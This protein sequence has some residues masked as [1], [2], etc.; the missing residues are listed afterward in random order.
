MDRGIVISIF[1]PTAVGKTGVAEIVR[2]RLREAGQEVEAVSADAYAV[3]REIPIITGAPQ[4]SEFD[5][6][7]VGQLSVTDEWSAGAFAKEA[8][9][10]IDTCLSKGGAVLMVGGTGLYLQAALSDLQMREAVPT[11]VRAA[12]TARL[13]MEGSEALHRELTSLQPNVSASIHPSDSHRVTRALEAAL[14]GQPPV[15]EAGIWTANLRQPTRLF[16]LTMERAPLRERINSRIEG[17]IAAGAA[18]EVEGAWAL[19]PSRTAQAAIGMRELPEGDVDRMR[20]RTHQF[21]KRQET[22][23]RK[24]EHA[25]IVD[26]SNRSD[27]SISDEIIE[28][29]GRDPAA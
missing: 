13:E 18:E 8:K 2:S 25:T 21:A 27:E 15:A 19:S 9:A 12:M 6:R 28:L 23:M 14:L 20:V 10:T 5:W 3:Y 7:T 11:D 4:N 1:G 22:W 29:L 17:M 24:L 16:G 26:A